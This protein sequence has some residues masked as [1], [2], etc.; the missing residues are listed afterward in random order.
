[1]SESHFN[2]TVIEKCINHQYGIITFL[3]LGLEEKIRYMF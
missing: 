1:M 3:R 2:Y